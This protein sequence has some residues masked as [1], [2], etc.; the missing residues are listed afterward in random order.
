MNSIFHPPLAMLHKQ[1]RMG[2]IVLKE[3]LQNDQNLSKQEFGF[4][5]TFS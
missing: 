3:A 4:I 2:H 5:M 1:L